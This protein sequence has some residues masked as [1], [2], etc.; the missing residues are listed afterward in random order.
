MTAIQKIACLDD[1]QSGSNQMCVNPLLLLFLMQ[2]KTADYLENSL[3]PNIISN[4]ELY[5]EF[6]DK[7]QEVDA[8]TKQLNELKDKISSNPQNSDSLNSQVQELQNKLNEERAQMEIIK[9]D[10]QTQWQTQVDS[11]ITS[12]KSATEEA[13]F[14]LQN[15]LKSEKTW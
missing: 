13:G 14:M 1:P 9:N 15:L 7:K 8:I 2:A 12:M 4:N 10:V 11:T 3:K 6:E 5:K